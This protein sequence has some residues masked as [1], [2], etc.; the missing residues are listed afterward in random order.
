MSSG[1]SRRRVGCCHRRGPARCRRSHREPNSG[2]TRTASLLLHSVPRNFASHEMIT[3]LQTASRVICN[4]L[5]QRPYQRRVTITAWDAV[6]DQLMDGRRYGAFS[7]QK[8]V[9]T[10]IL[11]YISELDEKTK[12]R[13]WEASEDAEVI[14]NA[15]I[16][17]I[18]ECLYPIIFQATFPRI[19]R[20][21]RQR[22][23]K[24][25]EPA[26]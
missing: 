11:R 6:V 2:C 3:E 10:E 21:V 20:V 26:D 13:I 12:R 15:S 18:T 14:P 23:R 25:G 9:K 7:W 17:T 4:Q 5:R 19:H 8:A 16:E 1:I 24:E 22:E